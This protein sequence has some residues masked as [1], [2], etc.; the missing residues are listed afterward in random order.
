[1]NRLRLVVA[2]VLLTPAA[3]RAQP[4]GRNIAVFE[5]IAGIAGVTPVHIDAG[6]R[7]G[8]HAGVRADAGLQGARV[9]FGVGARVW[10]LKSTQEFGGAGIDGF[11]LGEVRLGTSTRTAI[12]ATAGWG[13]DEIDE[14]HGSSQLSAGASGAT[15]SLGIG[16]ELVAPSGSLVILSADLIVPSVDGG[17]GRR[18]PVLEFGAGFRFRATQSIGPISPRAARR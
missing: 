9:A 12:R 6:N 15:W 17:V 3:V 14:G 7:H 2:L 8:V 5:T 4:V 13:F 18:R 16:R 11:V 10:Q 1:M